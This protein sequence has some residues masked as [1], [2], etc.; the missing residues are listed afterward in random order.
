M[1]RDHIRG[2]APK[3]II[4]SWIV[5]SVLA[6]G[7]AIAALPPIESA[8]T[9]AVVTND[10]AEVAEMDA[11]KREIEDREMRQRN[12][13]LE[14]KDQ[15]ASANIG[16]MQVSVGMF[17]VLITA[18]VIFF[19]I[20]TRDS[21]IAAATR[22]IEEKREEI[23]RALTQIRQ[24]QIE[25]DELSEAIRFRHAELED[26]AASILE[27]AIAPCAQMP[28]GEF[29]PNVLPADRTTIR[30]YVERLRDTPLHQRSVSQTKIMLASDVL[31]QDWAAVVAYS[32]KIR[33]IFSEDAEIC[34][35]T[36]LVEVVAL[37]ES[38]EM[39]RAIELSEVLF[40]RFADDGSTRVLRCA[41]RGL[42]Y[43]SLLETALFAPDMERPHRTLKTLI[44]AFAAHRHDADIRET[45]DLAEAQ[46]GS[47]Q[48]LR[49]APVAPF[50]FPETG[51]ARK[52]P[53]KPKSPKQP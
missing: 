14:A 35:L 24:R 20:A 21:A 29:R 43:R 4:L 18:T 9:L 32:G 44:S 37:A 51:R 33:S 28:V 47:F 13:I 3:V 5:L 17:G 16:W 1:I 50:R 2:F 10:Q 19:G 26:Q 41:A 11:I 23:E 45:L 52:V 12:A 34:S 6:I 27:Q 36:G 38:N 39:H 15:L 46:L 22:G 49:A 30:S 8:G 31:R 42:L 40:R 53:R 25:L 48:Q 7:P